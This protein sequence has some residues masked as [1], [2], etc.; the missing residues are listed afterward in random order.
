MNMPSL[1]LLIVAGVL[2]GT[3]VYLLGERT[4]SRIVIGLALMSN[5]VNLLLLG[6]GGAAGNPPLVGKYPQETMADPLPQAM[7]LTAIVITLGT[8]AFML[9]MAYRSM[10]LFG[11]DEVVDDLEDARLAKQRDED[12]ERAQEESEDLEESLD[13]S[14]TELS[15]NLDDDTDDTD[16]DTSDTEDDESTDHRDKDKPAPST[17]ITSEGEDQ[18]V[19]R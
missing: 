13:E 2:V 10:R 17:Q 9:A 3:G 4:L 6:A 19:S 14:A 18:G 16:D 5:G 7:I 15:E 8:T 1:A 12:D 11:H